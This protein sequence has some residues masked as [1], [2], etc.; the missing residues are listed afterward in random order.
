[1]KFLATI[2]LMGFMGMA[3]FGLI[4][5]THQMSGHSGSDCLASFVVGNIICPDGN[6]SFSYAFYHIQ[7]YQFFGN[8]FIS[9]FAAISAVIALAFVLAFI[10]IEIDNRLVLKSQI[11]YLKKRFSEIIDSLIS[12]RG[13][14]IR[15][16]SLLENS[17]SAR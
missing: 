9:S 11:F 2:L 4:G 12:S 1:M 6:D 14:F 17:P 16:L 15:W 5:M 8:A 3:L 13:N 10:F 7:A